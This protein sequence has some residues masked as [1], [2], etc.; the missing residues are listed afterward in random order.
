MKKTQ[1]KKPEGY[2]GSL[3]SQPSPADSTCSSKTRLPKQLHW[4]RLDQTK[5]DLFLHERILKIIKTITP[6]NR[7][8]MILLCL[9]TKYPVPPLLVYPLYHR[10]PRVW[11]L[12][13]N[14]R[15]KR[16]RGGRKGDVWPDLTIAWVTAGVAAAASLVVSCKSSK[17]SQ[18]KM[19][20]NS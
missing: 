18:S 10:N 13:W 8:G 1:R 20:W 19:S 7:L 5:V 12:D 15:K 6:Q 3:T 4:L 9:P 16:G 17:R 2:R 14:L 11:R